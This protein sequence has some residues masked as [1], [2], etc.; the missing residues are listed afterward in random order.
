MRLSRHKV[1]IGIAIF[2]GL[3]GALGGMGILRYRQQA[4]ALRQVEVALAQLQ[5]R[6]QIDSLALYSCLFGERDLR[7]ILG[8]RIPRAAEV[9][10]DIPTLTADLLASYDRQFLTLAGQLSQQHDQLAALQAALRQLLVRNFLAQRALDSLE[11]MLRHRQQA[12]DSLAQHLAALQREQA[13]TVFDT[14]TLFSPKGDKITFF[15][16]LQGG[17]PAGFGVGLYEGKGY[18]I[19]EWKGNQRHGQ[20]RHVY[21]DGSVYEG[22]FAGDKREGFGIYRYSTGAVYIGHWHENLMEGQGELILPEGKILKGR[23]VA[24]KLKLKE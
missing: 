8:Q 3:A 13:R 19:G 9:G 2:V 17:Q 5:Y 1:W 18:Y 22:C 20:G 7:A 24:G 12:I 4:Q 14:L 15:G 21:R 23:W 16:R 6:Y 11:R 10:S